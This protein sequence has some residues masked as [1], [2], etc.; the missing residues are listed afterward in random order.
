V[1][2]K[3]KGMIEVYVTVSTWILIFL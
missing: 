3:V 2:G 1:K